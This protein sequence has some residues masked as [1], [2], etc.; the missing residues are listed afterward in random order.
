MDVLG[1]V[2]AGEVALEPE[3]ALVRARNVIRLGRERRAEE[4]FP[5]RTSAG[6]EWSGD[7]QIK[8]AAEIVLRRIEEVLVMSESTIAL[9]DSLIG[10]SSEARS[11]VAVE[12]IAFSFGA[13]V[14]R[15]A[16]LR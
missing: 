5:F 3:D 1:V 11:T 13:R 7:E 15:P 14:S 4:V 12:G 9:I 2:T 10:E 8:I 6:R 16:R